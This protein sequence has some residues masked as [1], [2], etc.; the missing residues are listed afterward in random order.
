MRKRIS[1]VIT[2]LTAVCICA[3]ICFVPIKADAQN[4]VLL[5]WSQEVIDSAIAYPY[6]ANGAIHDMSKT[7]PKVYNWSASIESSS[8]MYFLALAEYHDST[9]KSTN[10]ITVTSR[11]LEHV[12]NFLVGG[13]EPSC[14]GGN[15][16]WT[17]NAIAQTLAL[18]KY[19][20]SI[21]NTLTNAEK[22]KCDFIMK[23]MLVAGNYLHNTANNPSRDMTQRNEWY[24]EW[25]P[26]LVEGSLGVMI[27]GYMYF[28]SAEAVNEI[29]LAFSYDDYIATMT[30]Y[31]YINMKYCFT[32]TGKARLETGNTTDAGGGR[33]YGAKRVFEY[34]DV[35]PSGNAKQIEYDPMALYHSLS[36][37]MYYHTCQSKVY[38]GLTLRGWIAD[39]TTSPFEG[40]KGMGFEMISMDAHGIRT[41]LDYINTGWRNNVMTR[42]TLQALGYFHG[43]YASA[44]Q[45]P[46]FVGTEDF[47]YKARHGYIG[48]EK[49]HQQTEPKYESNFKTFGYIFQKEIWDKYLKPSS[50]AVTTKLTKVSGY[51]NAEIRLENNFTGKPKTVIAYL[52]I[53]QGNKL[54]DVYSTTVTIESNDKVIEKDTDMF[55]ALGYLGYSARE[56]IVLPAGHTARLMVWDTDDELSPLA[57][58]KEL[59]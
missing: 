29:L 14:T 31:G 5:D 49:G 52:N 58:V 19:T 28:G 43:S 33:V 25:N 50:L 30:G 57:D 44:I 34:T 45:M 4:I 39:G 46:M 26:N 16:G 32:Q 6:L 42:A 37:R 20:P 15:G 21:W 18:I 51:L 56:N 2:F 23:A 53:Y 54:V 11:L 22:E 10:G 41:D 24:K 9:L 59:R 12:R 38:D 40:K 8:V 36:V 7:P 27:A 17:D 47:M 35:P 48:Y 1:K 3:G 55:F 13:R